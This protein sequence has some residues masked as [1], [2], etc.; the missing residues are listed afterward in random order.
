MMPQL[1][2]DLNNQESFSSLRSRRAFH[3]WYDR[4]DMEDGEF[5]RALYDIECLEKDYNEVISQNNQQI[6][7]EKNDEL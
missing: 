1:R 7:N 4:E 6:L 2:V 3:N 5:C